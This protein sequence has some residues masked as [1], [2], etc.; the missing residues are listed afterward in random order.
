[1]HITSYSAAYHYKLVV[2]T[3]TTVVW[4]RQI[5]HIIRSQWGQARSTLTYRRKRWK[6]SEVKPEDKSIRGVYLSLHSQE[7]LCILVA[8]YNVVD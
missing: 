1:M 2:L 7:V 4:Q 6:G 8:T 5:Y 3:T